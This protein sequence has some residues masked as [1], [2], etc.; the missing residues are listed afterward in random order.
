MSVDRPPHA[1]DLFRDPS[2]A[3]GRGWNVV[4]T[5]S[6]GFPRCRDKEGVTEV[7][8]AVIALYDAAPWPYPEGIWPLGTFT[9]QELRDHL[10]NFRHSLETQDDRSSS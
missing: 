1:A 8:A 3:S 10:D 7:K 5:E 6:C 4:H 2:V 9:A